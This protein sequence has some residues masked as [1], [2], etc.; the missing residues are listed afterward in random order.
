MIR[1]RRS[2]LLGAFRSRWLSQ[3][4]PMVVHHTPGQPE[5]V[6]A[7]PSM[8]MQGRALAQALKAAGAA[9]GDR[10]AWDGPAGAGWIS[11][12]VAALR[13][14][15][16]FVTDPGAPARWRLSADGVLRGGSAPAGPTRSISLRGM[17]LSDEQLLTLGTAAAPAA[18]ALVLCAGDWGVP[19]RFIHG[20]LAAMLAP[21]E[22]LLGPTAP[23]AGWLA[24]TG[25]TPDRLVCDAH[26]RDQM[27]P[28]GLPAQTIW[29][30]VSRP[31][32][33]PRSPAPPARRRSPAARR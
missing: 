4:L 31:P 13:V 7:A 22:L 20:P 15:G 23:A 6:C 26:Q 19:S 24:Q 12:F 21:A 9:P 11:A 18:G 2:A 33:A 32:P 16:C 5:S 29:C 27:F 14:E 28:D 30:A 17:D 25:S 3:P 1:S 8:W 10:I